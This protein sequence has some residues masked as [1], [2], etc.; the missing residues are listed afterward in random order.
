MLF[1]LVLAADKGPTGE[2]AHDV[3]SKERAHEE[4]IDSVRERQ[5]VHSRAHC[6]CCGWF[7]VYIRTH[8]ERHRHTHTHMPMQSR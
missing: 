2:R 6:Y 7:E 4:S 8:K 5:R 1:M 3:G